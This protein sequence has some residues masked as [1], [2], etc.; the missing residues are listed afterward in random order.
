MA[1]LYQQLPYLLWKTVKEQFP[2]QF[3][4]T[5]IQ[6]SEEEVRKSHEKYKIRILYFSCKYGY[7]IS[8]K[9]LKQAS[10]THTRKGSSQTK[11]KLTI[12]AATILRL[13]STQQ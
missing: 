4:T 5:K 10:K 1:S 13:S 2:L 3:L 11:N 6:T 7:D 9:H 8:Y 12:Y